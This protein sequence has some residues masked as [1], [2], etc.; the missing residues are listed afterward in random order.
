[1]CSQKARKSRNCVFPWDELPRIRNGFAFE[2][3]GKGRNPAEVIEEWIAAN[4]DRV[5]SWLG[6]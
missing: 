6:L 5:D 3:A 2:I 1:M 4:S